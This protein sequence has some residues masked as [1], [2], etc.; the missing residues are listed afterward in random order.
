MSTA[1]LIFILACIHVAHICHL[2][3]HPHCWKI[4]A[5]DRYAESH[6]CSVNSVLGFYYL[7]RY[8]HMT[9]A[10]LSIRMDYIQENN[11]VFKIFFYLLFCKG[12]P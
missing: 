12:W 4:K 7:V 6:L 1:N 3:K 8:L 5:N 11:E 10:L 2:K 9:P